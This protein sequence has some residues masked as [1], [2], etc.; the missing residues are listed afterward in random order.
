MSLLSNACK[1][2]PDNSDIEIYL[3]EKDDDLEIIVKDYGAGI[4]EEERDK[5]FTPFY[6]NNNYIGYVKGTGL[7]LSIA[8]KAVKSIG[9]AITFNSESGEGSEFKVIIPLNYV[10]L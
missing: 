7:G 3:K 8:Q 6:R 5:I 10:P 9:G 4:S 1:Y 2:S